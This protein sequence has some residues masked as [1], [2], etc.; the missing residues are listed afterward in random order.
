MK[1]TQIKD[2][3]RNISKKLIAFLSISVIV[4]LG[5]GCFLW[6]VFIAG[7]IKQN[8]A[9]FYKALKFS[10]FEMVSSLG[11][12]EKD[13]SEIA[14]VEGVSA[15]EGVI[16]FD[17]DV[18]YNGTHADAQ[19]FSVTEKI[20]LTKVESGRLP[21]TAAEC[22]VDAFFAD[23]DGI[24][25]GDKITVS[26]QNDVL[27]NNELTVVGTVNHPSYIR[28]GRT[29]YVIVS[30]SA[31]DSEA[32]KGLFTKAVILLDVP[33]SVPTF[34]QKYFDFTA[35][36]AEK[37]EALA[38]TL[39]KDRDAEIKL[40]AA[41]EYEKAKAE[42]D[43]AISDGQKEI[44]KGEATLREE[45]E[46]GEKALADA[47]E[48]IEAGEREIAESRKKI[49][50]GERLISENEAKAAVEFAK[51]QEQIDDGWNEYY[52]GSIKLKSSQKFVYENEQ[53]LDEKLEQVDQALEMATNIRS[54]VDSV[55][56]IVFGFIGNNIASN[57]LSSVWNSAEAAYDNYKSKVID[58]YAPVIQAELEG[59]DSSKLNEEASEA[60]SQARQEFIY[61]IP[62]LQILEWA[63]QYITDPGLLD[64]FN[65][66]KNTVFG[67]IEDIA[68]A[69]AA[70]PLLD[71]A[72]AKIEEAKA[73]IETGKKK[74]IEAELE[75]NAGTKELE[76]QKKKVQNELDAAKAEIA[77]GKTALAK[78]EA[79][80][81]DAKR[82]YEEGVEKFNTEK[83][84]GEQKLADA[85]REFAE[86]K[87]E[88]EEKLAEAE[89]M[90]SEL[91]GSNWLLQNRKMNAGY[92]DTSAST[93]AS[94]ASSVAF[95]SLFL[96]VGALVCFSTMA[97]IIGEQKKLIGATKAFGFFGKEIF[98]KY[99]VFGI[100]ATVFGL[101]LGLLAAYVFEGAVIGGFVNTYAYGVP[102]SIFDVKTSAI[103]CVIAIMLSI[104][105][106]AVS[107]REVLVKPA[108]SLMSGSDDMQKKRKIA[109]ASG[110]GS[111]FARLITRN[112]RSE[113]SRV[114]V[115]VAI[116]LG[117]VGII[118]V[119]FS[120][121]FGYDGMLSKQ[122]TDIVKYDYKISCPSSESETRAE[123]EKAMRSVGA[124]FTSVFETACAIK[125]KGTNEATVVIAADRSELGDFFSA[126]DEFS[127][128]EIEIP[129]DGIIIHSKLAEKYSL[130]KGDF[131][132]IFDQ[133][134]KTHDVEIKGV[135]LNYMG[136]ITLMSKEMRDKTFG[137]GSSDNFY[138]VNLN[139]ADI[140]ALKEAIKAISPEIG[141][142]KADSSLKNVQTFKNLIN[143]IIL[144]LSFM[145]IFMM[146]MILTNLTNIFIN[147]RLKDIAIMRINGFSLKETTKYLMRETIIMNVIGTAL[148]VVLGSPIALLIQR[149]MEQV[150][151]RYVRTF[152][153][154]AWG[155][156]VGLTM[157]AAI[158]I[159]SIA[160]R[161]IR[162]LSL[163]DA[164]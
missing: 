114:I 29:N 46:K 9:D 44:E 138:Y 43:S 28:T 12:T 42:F 153:P 61:S 164:K 41:E 103:V 52:I 154:L 145:A 73:E 106:T 17:A 160:F 158:I 98:A 35:P 59:K 87:A 117:S 75:L 84:N 124:D 125:I 37:L 4:L 22:V 86:K 132:T 15:V 25:L 122:Y 130:K 146:V 64:K 159:N 53:T 152:S 118:G 3:L 47:L 147:K 66:A 127:G 92:A 65:S 88:G 113:I 38:G 139:G 163:T 39:A 71:D 45:L 104:V 109:K 111:V 148:G 49:E 40:T 78:G 21:E 67:Y 48:K 33:D 58:A 137:D 82:Q 131:I 156:A 6:T 100:V 79:E 70:K 116:I 54:V 94:K 121:K 155:I 162:K 27:V 133:S 134:L 101:A 18:T 56:Y 151:M 97:I 89:K 69:A 115:S 62:V 93:E 10:D 135:F 123:L 16:Q 99:A 31:F 19:L 105:T 23:S 72:K 141:V 102:R 50:D 112:M 96:I 14:K 30:K 157:I 11:V 83:A 140:T 68:K 74:L 110:H 26:V 57:V 119:G 8:A 5:S 91:P 128:K 77:E 20:N 95:A 80:L 149:T 13:I 161:K 32:T 129:T 34:S 85:K 63:S 142:E 36:I 1:K 150:D 7:S 76:E 2:A 107:C 60:I 136:R 90:L 126:K 144:G 55:E 24:K 120:I 143:S 51:A 108:S 81:E